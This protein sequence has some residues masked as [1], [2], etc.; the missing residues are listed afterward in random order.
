[1][2]EEPNEIIN[3]GVVT[4]DQ[5]CSCEWARQPSLDFRE[6]RVTVVQGNV[7]LS[8]GKRELESMRAERENRFRC[9]AVAGGSFKHIPLM[10]SSS[11][12]SIHHK[13]FKYDAFLSFRGEDTRKNFVDHLYHA[14]QEKSI[15]TYKDDERINKGKRISDE[16]IGSIE[17]SKYF[18]IVF[19]KNYACSS[20]CLDELVKIMECH[21]TTEH[22]AYPVFY[23]VEPTEVRK[24][25]GAVGEAFAKYENDEAAGKWRKAMKEAADLAGW[26]LKNTTHGHEAKFIQ[27]IV[28]EVSIELRSIN[29][30]ADENL[31][32]METRITDIVSS[33][34][35]ATDDLHRFGDVD[36]IGIRGMGG[37]GKTTL[38]RAV[39][40]KISFQ[41]EG[42]SFIE[43]VREISKASLFG[44]K[45]LQNKVLSDLLNNQGINTGS[46]HEM[47]KM[48]RRI[49][50]AKKLLLV[51][52]DVDHIDQ[53]EAIAG[54]RYWFKPGS[55]IIITTREKQVLVAHGVKL[56]YNVNLL[57]DKE[58][59]CLFGKYAF[60]R[61]I[62]K[63]YEELSRQVVC[64]AAG[65]PLTIKVL[66]SFLCDND[67]MEIFLDVATMLKG[68]SKDS[69]IEALESC[70]FHARIGLRVLEQKSLISIDDYELVGMH[71]HLE[72]MAKNIVCLSHP[73]MTKNHSRLWD[74][75]EI[76]DILANDV[77]TEATRCI[78][79]EWRDL[80]LEV[81]MKSLI[82]PSFPDDLQYLRWNDYPRTSLPKTFQA[83]NLVTLQMPDSKILQLWEDGER[84]VL[85]KLRF[86]DLSYSMLKTFDLG[87]T[88]NL[89][90]LTLKGCTN[91]SQLHMSFECPT[92]R[93]LKLS[94]SKVRTLDLLRSLKFSGSKLRTL[95]L[96]MTPILEKL[97]ISGD[98]VKLYIRY[99]CLKL[100]SLKLSCSN[101]RTLDL[102][103]TPNLEKLDL[104]E[105]S[106]LHETS[107][108][109]DESLE[110]GSLAQ[111]HFT[112]ERC[113]IH[114]DSFFPKF[115]FTCFQKEDM[116]SWTR[117]LEKLISVG[118][119]PCDCKK[120][121]TFRK[122]LVDYNVKNPKAKAVL[123]NVQEEVDHFARKKNKVLKCI[124]EKTFEKAP[125]KY[126]FKE[127]LI[128]DVFGQKEYKNLQ[129]YLQWHLLQLHPIP[130][131]LNT[132]TNF[133][134]HLYSALQ[135]KNIFTFRDDERIG[136]GKRISD[137]LIG[138]IEDSK[139]FII[140]FSKNYAS[141]FWCLDEL[142][143]IMECQKTIEQTAYPVFYDVNPS[144]VRKQIGAVGEAF[145][146]LDK[147]EA[148][149]KW[150]DALKV[151]VYPTSKE[152]TD[153][154][155]WEV[156][157]TDDGHEAKVI[158]RIVDEISLQLRYINFSIDE[159]LVGMETR[160]N[161]FVSSLGIASDDV[162]MI[163]IW[164]IGGGGKTTLAR[165]VFNKI[166][167]EFECKSFIE[168][169]RE[170]SNASLSGLILL[171]KQVLSDVLND[172][173][174]NISSVYDGKDMMKRRMR[175]RKVL[176][177]LDDV[178]HIHQLEALAGDL[179]WFKAGSRIIITTRDEQVLLAHRLK[180]IHT[181][182]LLSVKE[183]ICLFSRYAF[184]TDSPI[185]RHE[186]LSRQF[187][188]YSA[189]LPLTI[190]VLGSF[191]YGKNESE[192]IDALDRLKT[193][194]LNETLKKLELSYIGL[195]E[196]YKEIF[197][198]VACIL[199]GELKSYAIEVLESCGFHAK[200]GLRVLEQKS[201]ITIYNKYNDE[202]VGMHDHLEEMGRDI[203]RRFHV[204]MPNK[205]S[206]LWDSRAIEDIL[207]NDLF[208]G[209]IEFGL[210]GTEST[211]CIKFHHGRLD[212]EIVMKGLRKMK[213]L[214]FLDVSLQDLYSNQEI[215]GLMQNFLNI[216]E[217]MCCN[218]K[219]YEGGPY[220]PSTLRYL[221]WDDYR[222]RYLPKTLQ[223]DN[224]VS[225]KMVDSEIV[226]L[227]EGRE[228]KVLKK[229]RFLDLSYSMLRTFDLEL[230]PNL[231]R[232]TLK[233]CRH[234]AELLMPF[235]C[236]K[237]KY[238][239]LDGSKLRTLDLGLTPNL[240][241][242][243]LCDCNNFVEL[244][245]P[246]GGFPKLKYLNLRGLKLS[247]LDMGLAPNLE[248]LSLFSCH[249]FVELHMP[250]RCL[251]LRSLLIDNSKFRCLN[252]GLTPKLDVLSLTSCY[253]LEVLHMADECQKLRS[254]FISRSKLRTLD[255][256]LTPNL[257]GLHLQECNDLVELHMPSISLNLRSIVLYSSKLRT[258]ALALTPNLKSLY[259]QNCYDLEELD[260]PIG[261]LKNIVHL[262]LT[263]CLGFTSFSFHIKHPSSGKVN[264]SLEVPTLA[265]LHFTLKRCQFH[266]DNNLPKFEFTC[267]H[268]SDLSSL[269]ITL[270]KLI[271]IG[272]CA[273]I[274]LETFQE[275]FVGYKLQR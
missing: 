270:E 86:L 11:T 135:Q 179:N 223:A 79:F 189:G 254:L 66:G 227:W 118:E 56:I 217:F 104:N 160:I 233:G 162:R 133:T 184:G 69:V 239:K 128:G 17:D 37:G 236:A 90:T 7:C 36:M 149:G 235:K 106:N 78:Q 144:E 129:A 88:P 93:S 3:S 169:I 124:L 120:L 205:H 101:V 114:L 105:C 175:N 27:T 208:D 8:Q 31:V 55:I 243:D 123:H 209:D 98:L 141:S 248:T 173:R 62:P 193:I 165:A 82:S 74:S 97:D 5:E 132:R 161:N 116:P 244:H 20:W 210:Q 226:Q 42:K 180:L 122:A 58:A 34:R 215:N 218:W 92:I 203:V 157:K 234:L 168:N 43:N 238:L 9:G 39:F 253:Y 63:E 46:E 207:A 111:L 53:L 198:D 94:D 4:L 85:N 35:I 131:A 112:P 142:V 47:N 50:R 232:L 267:Y 83:N 107:Y 51:L 245:V 155:G 196:D 103:L 44:L 221:R 24:Q 115:Q 268:K 25:S 240:E 28:E 49:M 75:K 18:I 119:G 229:L 246:V 89:E 13:S 255:L 29:Y 143:K 187:V 194:P 153:L 68:W 188:L 242:L 199:K 140:V 2:Q 136:K 266:P 206:R 65:L 257:E 269:T 263:S 249:D 231:E 275:A 186:E 222:F 33:L 10:A 211:R 256:R 73:T 30:R 172:Q 41:F 197:L 77:G 14:L 12:A 163:G 241:Q 265:N 247:T 167:F 71:D 212:P 225:L 87:I 72:E 23:D 213:E 170:V 228:R 100:K 22:I 19:S 251:N 204:D 201:L 158:K 145:A 125:I 1:M 152:A 96:G 166:C 48:L 64:Y 202:C 262:E 258:L 164:G 52:D 95:D 224:I 130:R 273:C 81:I 134:D 156:K 159:K 102:R 54:N 264:E 147:L 219:F 260:T 252:I 220:F 183:G 261:W 32:G 26:E 21:K 174:I 192:W 70:G 138:S 38:A 117:H 214:R 171:Q 16:L 190:R 110:V 80:D 40:N 139:F 178:D 126:A 108:N 148:T 91:L 137:E 216:L 67:F 76:E 185:E 182:D 127:S 15:H 151:L 259:L 230:T 176:L 250:R 274:K 84:K 121:E 154:A 113:P 45:S 181:V 237:L 109:T 200:N 99:E 272:P 191:L 61:D 57:S 60:G 271:S 59:I 146:K 150:R 177:V 195:E 6:R